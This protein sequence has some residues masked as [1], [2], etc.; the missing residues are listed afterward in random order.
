MIIDA[1]NSS[2]RQPT[3]EFSNHGNNHWSGVFL[4]QE[5]AARWTWETIRDNDLSKFDVTAELIFIFLLTLARD[6]DALLYDMYTYNYFDGKEQRLNV[7]SERFSTFGTNV[8]N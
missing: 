3:L 6:T 7:V 8:D 1:A 2:R 5:L 4:H